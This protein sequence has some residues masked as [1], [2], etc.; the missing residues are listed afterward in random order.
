MNLDTIIYKVREARYTAEKDRLYD[1]VSF[2][3]KLHIYLLEYKNNQ[4]LKSIDANIEFFEATGKV[5]DAELLIATKPF[6]EKFLSGDK[7]I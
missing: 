3:D 7:Q 4:I 6:I 5:D 1:Y 2:Y